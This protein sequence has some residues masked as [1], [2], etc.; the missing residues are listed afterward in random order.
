MKLFIANYHTPE[1]DQYAVF[2]TQNKA[3]AWRAAIAIENWKYYMDEVNNSM[4]GKSNDEIA[5]QFFEEAAEAGE[6]FI[7]ESVELDKT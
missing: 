5:D 6:Y 1:S 7:I 3:K 2:S 4:H